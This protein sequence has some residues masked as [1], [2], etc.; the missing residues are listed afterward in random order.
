MHLRGKGGFACDPE[1]LW[2]DGGSVC[3]WTSCGS[4]GSFRSGGEWAGSVETG[5]QDGETEE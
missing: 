3:Q 1:K 5:Q 4:V 2:G